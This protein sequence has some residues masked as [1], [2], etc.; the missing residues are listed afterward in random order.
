VHSPYTDQFSVKKMG[1]TIE[2]IQ[3]L[4]DIMP[5]DVIDE[6]TKIGV[7]NPEYKRQNIQD[8]KDLEAEQ[9]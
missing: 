8:I 4:V 2:E 3:E 9:I 5:E 1:K 6:F 7:H